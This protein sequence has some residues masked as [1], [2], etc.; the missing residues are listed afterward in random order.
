MTHS[1]FLLLVVLLAP[2]VSARAATYCDDANDDNGSPYLTMDSKCTLVTYDSVG[3]HISA[4]VKG[5]QTDHSPLGQT[6]AKGVGGISNPAVT[7]RRICGDLPNGKTPGNPTN[8][9]IAPSSPHASI[10]M[11]EVYPAHEGHW[12]VCARVRNW[13]NEGLNQG[14]PLI[15]AFTVPYTN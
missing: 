15:F 10:D 4:S 1:R 6:C 3:T 14:K 5:P 8:V 12:T 9:G 2:L 7:C 13:H 11:F